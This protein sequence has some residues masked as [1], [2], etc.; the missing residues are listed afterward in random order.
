MFVNDDINLYYAT[1]KEYTK[2]PY[3]HVFS[4]QQPW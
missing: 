3:I 1:Q 4:S 2:Q